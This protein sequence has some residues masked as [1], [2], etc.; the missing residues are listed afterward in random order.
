MAR[1]KDGIQPK[2]KPLAKP[3]SIPP[4]HPFFLLESG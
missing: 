1:A 2:N 4:A 3:L